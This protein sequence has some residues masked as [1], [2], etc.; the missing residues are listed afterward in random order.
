[1]CVKIHFLDFDK[2]KIIFIPF[3]KRENVKGEFPHSLHFVPLTPSSPGMWS[4]SFITN[5]DYIFDLPV[6]ISW[7]LFSNWFYI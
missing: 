6:S 2:G 1:M 7:I 3:P 4:I 5:K